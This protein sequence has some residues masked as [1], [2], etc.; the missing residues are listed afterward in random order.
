MHNVT[1]GS[2]F[3]EHLTTIPAI[4]DYGV[5]GNC[6][7][8]ALVSRAGSIDWLCLPR[9]DSPSLLARILDVKQGGFW[10]IQP[11]IEFE[12]SHHY[13]DETNV[14]KTTFTCNTGKMQ[15]L[16]FMEM[17]DSHETRHPHAPGRL[18]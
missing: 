3:L 9:F 16:D 12:S 8:A 18:I 13:L 5:I 10:A 1:S 6:H 4:S 17:T 14:L 11:A 7:T 15:L 2:K